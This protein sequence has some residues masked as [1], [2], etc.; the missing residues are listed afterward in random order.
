MKILALLP[1]FPYPPTRGDTVRA[2]S[3]VAHLARRHAVWLACVDGRPASAEPLAAIRGLFRD[4]AV[5]PR[6]GRR[7]LIRG[8]RALL[9]GRSLTEGFFRD[10]RLAETLRHWNGAVQ[11][12]AVFTF[13]S[14]MAP[15]AKLIDAGRRVLDLS[16]VDSAKWAAYARRSVWPLRWLYECEHRRV[17]KLETACANDHD[18]C[19]VVNERERGKFRSLPS[20]CDCR[21]VPVAV[22]SRDDPCDDAASD[23]NSR[24]PLVGFVGSLFYPPNVAAARW[25]A[26]DV[27]PRVRANRPDAEWLLVGARPTRAVRRLARIP[28][29]RLIENPPDASEYVRKLRV[30]VNPVRGDLGVQVKLLHALAAGRACVV[31]AD[32]A[33]GLELSEAPP[34]LIADDATTFADSVLRLLEDD[35]LVADLSAAA[36]TYIRTHHDPGEVLAHFEA[37]MLGRSIR[38]SASN[39]SLNTTDRK[40]S[41]AALA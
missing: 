30:F 23:A 9:A 41:A 29:V 2:W 7:A 19:L 11:F 27:W 4:V 5:I 10:A 3:E 25:F 20:T 38:V 8:A 17:Q 34:C 26:R 35:A 18:V 15:Y 22:E 13:S 33:G 37:C 24:N 1:R 36:R 21:V 40:L 39:R 31:T 14:A 32:A 16:D 12:D 28:G 6:D